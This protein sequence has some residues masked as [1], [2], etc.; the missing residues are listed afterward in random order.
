MTYISDII[1][2]NTFPHGVKDTECIILSLI[3]YPRLIPLLK[4]IFDV[5]KANDINGKHMIRFSHVLISLTKYYLNGLLL[6]R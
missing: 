5:C 3:I 4:Y 2:S 1:Y 6:I